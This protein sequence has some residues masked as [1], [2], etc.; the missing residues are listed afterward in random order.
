M[1]DRIYVGRIPEVG[2]LALAG[3]GVTFPVIILISAFAALVGAG[4][5]PRQPSVW[6]RRI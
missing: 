2:H 4:E 3:L 5:R 6:E 1:V